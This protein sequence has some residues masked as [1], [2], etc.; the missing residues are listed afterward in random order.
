MHVG[1]VVATVVYDVAGNCSCARGPLGVPRYTLRRRGECREGARR[2]SSNASDLRSEDRLESERYSHAPAT[3]P[4]RR[5]GRAQHHAQHGQHCLPTRNRHHTARHTPAHCST[6]LNDRL[7]AP[8]STIHN[9]MRRSTDQG[10]RGWSAVDQ[11]SR[12][13]RARGCRGVWYWGGRHSAKCTPLALCSQL[14]SEVS[15]TWQNAC[16]FDF[17]CDAHMAAWPRDVL[18]Y[19][20]RAGGDF[21][22]LTLYLSPDL[23]NGIRCDVQHARMRTNKMVFISSRSAALPPQ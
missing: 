11:R 14:T 23:G 19:N 12:V 3:A 4:A 18:C 22:E 1:S 6:L 20:V 15:L 8:Q 9:H 5:P 13:P 7:R 10:R 16:A 21:E 17:G 2:L